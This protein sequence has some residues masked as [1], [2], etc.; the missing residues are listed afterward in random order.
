MM[1]SHTPPGDVDAT[2]SIIPASPSPLTPS[3]LKAAGGSGRAGRRTNSGKVWV[4]QIAP[5]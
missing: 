1:L 2:G 3:E 5:R 4:N